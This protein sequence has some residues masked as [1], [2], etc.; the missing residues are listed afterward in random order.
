MREK[1]S[2]PSWFTWIP[3]VIGLIACCLVVSHLTFPATSTRTDPETGKVRVLYIGDGWGQSPVPRY[4]S[5]PAFTVM[6]VPTSE[7]HVGHGVMTFDNIAMKKFV[8]LY[9]PRTFEEMLDKYDLVIL[10]DA[11][12]GF[13][14]KEHILW[15]RNSLTEYGFGLVMVG[16]L[17]SFGGPRGVPWTP[18]EDV[19]PVNLIMGG[20]VYQSYKVKPATDHPFTRSLPW[21]TIPL[22]HGLNRV[23]LKEAA[24]LLLRADDIDYP[25]L[26]CWDVGEGRSVAHTPDWTPSGGTDV[27]RWEYYVDYVANIAFLATRNDI[28]QNAQLLHLLRTSFW[29]T[30]SRL[31]SVMDT[32]NFV[33]KFGANINKIEGR[34]GDVRTMIFDAERLYIRQD[35]DLARRTI[36]EID[37]KI[38][39][40]QGE[41]MRLKDLALLW[42]YIIEWTVTTG[43][44]LLAGF[45]LWTLMVKRRLYRE[46]EATR[47]TLYEH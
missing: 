14:G 34:L 16:G 8:R 4:Q 17:E 13:M 1:V 45:V 41:A 32:I 23:S 29:S 11:N 9:M 35:F 19:L 7:L 44:A 43:T 33:E 22:F 12:I 37:A 25:P 46:V 28:P 26:S 24:V 3:K 21:E 15:I 30:R 6:S 42:V 40:L 47:M 10:S 5:D 38:I 20:W 18:L 27:M 36:D 39:E 31:T 2:P